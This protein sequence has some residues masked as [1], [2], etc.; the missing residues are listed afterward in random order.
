ERQEGHELGPGIGPQLDHC[1]ILG[2]PGFGELQGS[3][4]VPFAGGSVAR[5]TD[6]VDSTAVSVI[7]R[8]SLDHQIRR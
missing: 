6:S 3:S 1:R 5:S 8:L 4:L 7:W 2:A